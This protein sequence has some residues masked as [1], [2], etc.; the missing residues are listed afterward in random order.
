MG[1]NGVLEFGRKEIRALLLQAQQIANE[2]AGIL[3][4]QSTGERDVDSAV[5]SLKESLTLQQLSAMPLEK[6]R[7][8]A[9]GRVAW[10]AMARG[11]VRTVADAYASSP[12]RL[13]AIRGVGN[14]SAYEVSKLARSLYTETLAGMRL[15]INADRDDPATQRLITALVRLDGINTGTRTLLPAA[16]RATVELEDPLALARPA[17]SG[18]RWLFTGKLRKEEARAAATRLAEVLA[19][20]TMEALSVPGIARG[21]GGSP[22]SDREARDAFIAEPARYLSLLDS[23]VGNVQ[24]IHG[25][26]DQAIVDRIEAIDLDTSL[27]K[28]MLRR[29]Q[30]FGAKFVLAQDRVILGDDMGLGKTI[31]AL[32]VM[33]HIAATAQRSAAKSKSKTKSAGTAPRFLVVAPASVLINWEREVAAKSDLRVFG[34]HGSR[35]P[36]NLAKWRKQG[37]VAI[38]T[39]EYTAN[40]DLG[41]G[42]LAQEIDLLIVDEAHYVK[43]PGAGRTQRVDRLT[44]HAKRVLMMTGTPI[45]NKATEFIDLIAMVN[46]E[47]GMGLMHRA[48]VVNPVEFKRKVAPAYLRRNAIDVLSELPERIEIDEW[49]EMTDND[50]QHYLKALESGN[51]MAIRRAGFAAASI[52]KSAKMNRLLEIVDEATEAG[53]KVIAYSY[54][55]DVLNAVTDALGDKAY[56]PMTGAMAP[57]ARQE[58]V[59][60]FTAAPA[61]SVLVS[62]V[63]AGGVGLNIQAA[64]IVIMCEPQLKPSTENQ[65]IARAHRMGQLKSVQVYRLLNPDSIDERIEEILSGKETVFAQYARDSELAEASGGKAIDGRTTLRL[66]QGERERLGVTGAEPVVDSEDNLS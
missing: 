27:L 49:E 25:D 41:A 50:E 51:F 11:G 16:R 47:I 33:C 39:F 57:P 30:A 19:D 55:L 7:P 38:T 62:Q 43:N 65:A 37:G 21:I 13:M 61:G 58:V 45:E 15:A 66:I 36:K 53:H 2:A 64:S 44:N 29:Y 9:S 52:G 22:T 5:E 20:P 1:E 12:S 60:E 54:F 28:V 18:L 32:A 59:D 31:Q 24:S 48:L 40:I 17:R 46:P 8:L 4:V 23:R 10:T 56:G 35:D 6:L 14:Q 42:D 26:L 63:V 34:L 3:S